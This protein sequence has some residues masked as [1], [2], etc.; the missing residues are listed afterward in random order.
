MYKIGPFSFIYHPAA[1]KK[2]FSHTEFILPGRGLILVSG[3]S[4]SGKSTFLNLLKGIIPEYIHGSLEGEILFNNKWLDGDNFE[5]NLKNIV[6]LFQ[7]PYSQIIHYETADEFFFSLEN[8]K[9]DFSDAKQMRANLS[10]KFDLSHLWEKKTLNLSHGECQKLLLASLLALSP[11]VLLLDEPTAFLDTYERK[12]F[13]DMLDVLKGDHL[14][15]MIDHHL[16]EVISK[17]DFLITVSPKGEIQLKKELD[18]PDLAFEAQYDL[19]DIST[20]PH[21]EIH[22]KNLTFS[23]DKIQTLIDIKNET[24][25]S[26]EVVIV[27]GRNG[28]GKSTLLKL[29]SAF[30]P[31]P[32]GSVAITL[33]EKELP[34]KKIFEQIGYIFQDPESSFLFDTLKEELG[35]TSFGFTSQELERSPHL[36]SEG[37]KRRISIFIAL[38]QNKNILL[39][40]EPTFGQD[41]SNI[42]K[43]TEIILKLKKMNK[44][45][46]IISHDEDFISAVGDRVLSL[47]DGI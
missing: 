26:G 32:K 1:E 18:R 44:L 3:P 30:I 43:L 31:S 11:Q 40:D 34:K 12:N 19:P 6:Y 27:K 5:R 23:Y 45:Q 15:V 41:A 25:H 2:L 16:K 28:T 9:T 39:Y 38:A 47:K 13:Y 8:F 46:I 33:D 37:E 7:N 17:V 4:G 10:K 22:I 29:I 24:L 35:E 21:L 20:A 36:F 14:I 42:K